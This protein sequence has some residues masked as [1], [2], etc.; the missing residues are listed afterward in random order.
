[1]KKNGK[2]FLPPPDDGKDLKEL[3][4][5]LVQSG[6]GRALGE[7]GFAKGP[8]TPELLAT[9]ISELETNDQG[10]D[11]RTV[12]LWFQDNDKGISTENITSLAR[13]FGCGD[14]T[15][16]KTLCINVFF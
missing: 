16:I 5:F 4:Q 11:L 14:R 10:I 2:F 8:W 7:D 12:Q 13:I 3:F 9:T 6:A 15:A 1:M